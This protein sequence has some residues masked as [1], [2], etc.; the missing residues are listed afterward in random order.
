MSFCDIAIKRNKDSI[1]VTNKSG[2]PSK[3]YPKI[4]EKVKPQ[5]NVVYQNGKSF[6]DTL[7]EQGKLMNNNPDELSLGLYSLA[8]NSNKTEGYWESR[9]DELLPKGE[10]QVNYQLKSIDIL[11]SNRAIELFEKG[12]K[13][14]WALDKILT[15]LTIPKEQKQ[16]IIDLNKSDRED[17]IVD[18]MSKYGFGVEINTTTEVENTPIYVYDSG[19]QFQVGEELE[20]SKSSFYSNLTVPGGTNYTENEISTPLITPSIKGHAQFASD[21]G[22]GWFRSD[23]K[24]KE[25]TFKKET[26][27]KSLDIS[28][29]PNEFMLGSQKYLKKNDE[30]YMSDLEGDL[31]KMRSVGL[32]EAEVVIAYQSL[33]DGNTEINSNYTGTNYSVKSNTYGT[34]IKTRR[35]LEVQSDLFQKGRDKKDL[36]TK[37]QSPDLEGFGEDF[38]LGNVY[39]QEYDDIYYKNAGQGLVEISKKEFEEAKKLFSPNVNLSTRENQFLQL[40]NKDNNWVKFFAQS[41]IQDSAKKG[42]EKVLFPSG[43]TASKVEGHTTLEEF[44]KQK[45]EAIKQRE[46]EINKIKNYSEK[47]KNEARDKT[48]IEGY[49][50]EISQF[51]QELENVDREGFGALKPIYNFYENTLKN[52]LKKNYPIKEVTDEYGNTWY[53]VEIKQERE[54]QPI[55]MSPKLN[56]GSGAKVVNTKSSDVLKDLATNGLSRD[57]R[58]TAKRLLD[59]VSKNDA[60]ILDKRDMKDGELQYNLFKN[61]IYVNAEQ[62]KSVNPEDYQR[63]ILHEIIHSLTINPLISREKELKSSTFFKEIKQVVS[64]LEKRV[65]T[66][67]KD[68]TKFYAF[69]HT[70]EDVK[71]FEFIAEY[72]SKKEF[73]DWVDARLTNKKSFIEK[74]V[75]FI[76]NVIFGKKILESAIFDYIEN[77]FEFIPMSKNE[78]REVLMNEVSSFTNQSVKEGVDFVFE[79]NPE[80]QSIGNK[81]LYSRYLDS[82]FPTSKVKD[83]VY[84]GS[85]NSNLQFIGFEDESNNEFNLDSMNSFGYYFQGNHFGTLKAAKDRR[86]VFIYPVILNINTI[87]ATKDVGNDMNWQEEILKAKKHENDGLI[88]KNKVEDINSNSYVVFSPKQI[89]ILGS[90]QD[91][92]GFRKYVNIESVSSFVNTEDS[93]KSDLKKIISKFGKK[94]GKNQTIIDPNADY[95]SLMKSIASINLEYPVKVVELYKAPDGTDRVRLI[96]DNLEKAA[97]KVKEEEISSIKKENEIEIQKENTSRMVDSIPELSY[98]SDDEKFE[99]ERLLQSGQ[100]NVYCGL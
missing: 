38:Y 65:P 78:Y 83:I 50:R 70:D 46:V 48:N 67:E 35:I 22:I 97:F 24:V 79:Q 82:I 43:N 14:N 9:I 5:S 53:E 30:W 96:K 61:E 99:A 86:D 64:D 87:K 32:G 76:A 90:Q 7:I 95:G 39:Y 69:Q 20:E 51:K 80:L 8:Y 17:I 59:S 52:I 26:K 71:I 19:E 28:G 92:E 49:E 6:F 55:L 2:Y 62:I 4:V 45:E 11:G 25:G 31:I 66:K 54:V 15:E 85:N 13:N 89:H 3:L 42:Y 100:F 21:K 1:E 98:L 60:P 37:G 56:Q 29:V 33:L 34:T 47:Q 73:A 18:L 36:V 88:Y 27:L 93:I 77:R 74:L 41:I 63:G 84:H 81:Q 10:N 58:L 68:N 91:I 57:I 16:L 12:R 40:L 44:K 75:A 72:L 94:F 23:D